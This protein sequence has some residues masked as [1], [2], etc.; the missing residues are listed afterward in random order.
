MIL[1]D[2]SI[3]IDHLR[4]SNLTMETF[5]RT[6]QIVIHPFI[7]AEIALG[8]LRNRKARLAELDSLQ[9]VVVARIE[10]V[11]HFIEARALYSRGLTLVD[12]HLLLSCLLT[13]GTQLWT[14]DGNMESVARSLG[15]AANLPWHE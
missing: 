1:A 11:R 3:W 4:K 15:I 8:S 9:Q 6:A 10:E 13:P 14:R 2:T 7:V 12:G 5:L